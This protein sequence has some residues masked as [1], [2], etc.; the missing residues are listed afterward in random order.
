MYKLTLTKS[1]RDAIDWI[2]DR[3]T[4][5]FDFYCTLIWECMNENDEW[6]Q[7]GDITFNIP[8][9]YAWE[10]KEGLEKEKYGF[11]C[12]SEELKSKLMDFCDKII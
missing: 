2:G 10:I 5:G 4:H 7:E 1:E 12:F 9:A 11:A 8:E 3:Y 6:C